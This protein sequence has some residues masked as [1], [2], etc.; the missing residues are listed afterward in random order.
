MK[1]RFALL[2]TIL[3]GQVIGPAT[4]GQEIFSDNF[5]TDTSA[6]WIVI[7]ESINE[8][9]DAT[10][11]FAHDYTTDE[12]T[13]TRGAVVD[14]LPVPKNPFDDGDTTLGLRLSVNSDD[15]A[16]AAAVSL[17]PANLSIDGDHALRF[18][19]FMSYNGSSY[20]TGGSGT[21]EL[22]TMGVGQSGNWVAYL[23]GNEALDGDGTF[24]AVSGEGGASRDFRAFAAKG[25][26]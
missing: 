9:P 18:E 17:F 19:M 2:L 10:V 8:I 15:D 3:M 12:F 26:Q 1:T 21:T 25:T 5:D 24:F 14:R 4:R 23:S 13:V 6:D 22:A 20:G 7:D 16:G 11:I